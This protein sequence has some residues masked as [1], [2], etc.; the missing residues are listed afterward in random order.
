MGQKV[1][2]D[3][4]WL[5]AFFDSEDKYHSKAVRE[6]EELTVLPSISAI[7]LA[8]LLVNFDG[9]DFPVTRDEIESA[10]TNVI[11][12]TKD[13]AILAAQIRS[14]NRV[15]LGD[16]LIIATALHTKSKLLTFDQS[17]KVVYERTK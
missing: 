3:T 12:V 2:A 8:E 5:I 10:L 16:A 7:T 17:M 6:F 15:T 9:K 11:E 13:I 14:S 1:H 4:S